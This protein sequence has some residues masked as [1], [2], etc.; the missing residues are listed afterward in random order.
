VAG[1]DRARREL[2]WTPQYETIDQVVA[3]AWQWHHHHPHGY[4]D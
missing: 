4:P 2:G 1:A 3:S